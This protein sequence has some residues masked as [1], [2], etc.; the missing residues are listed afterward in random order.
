MWELLAACR[1]P[2]GDEDRPQKVPYVLGHKTLYIQIRVP[3]T[4]FMGFWNI[5]NIPLKIS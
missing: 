2:A 5:K 1:E 3:Y 4:R